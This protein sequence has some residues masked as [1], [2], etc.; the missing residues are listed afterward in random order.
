MEGIPNAEDGN[1]NL[2]RLIKLG[3]LQKITERTLASKGVLG[4]RKKG[5]KHQLEKIGKQQK[6]VGKKIIENIP[7]EEID[8]LL[9]NLPS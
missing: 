4:E 9:G 8:S 1:E 5:Y 3:E 7:D 6:E 2:D